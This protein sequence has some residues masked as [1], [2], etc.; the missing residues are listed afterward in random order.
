MSTASA[1]GRRGWVAR[2][3]TAF[4]LWAVLLVVAR[5]F[6]SSPDP[7]LLGLTVATVAVTVWLFLDTSVQTESPLWTRHADDPF[8][9]PGEDARLSLL[10]RVVGQH[11][12]A[13]EVGDTLQRHLVELADQRLLARYGVAWRVDPE[14]AAPLLGPELAALARQTAPFPRMTVQHIDVLITRIEAL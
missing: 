14:R 6:G 12:D 9:P 2:I 13:Y 4:A 10:V 7:V 8:R 1:I 5:V 3:G 11:L